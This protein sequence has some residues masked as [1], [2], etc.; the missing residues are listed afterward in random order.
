MLYSLKVRLQIAMKILRLQTPGK[1]GF[2]KETNDMVLTVRVTPKH[3]WEIR[4]A[5]SFI[6]LQ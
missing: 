3:V 5:A 1:A 4:D 2:S 6:M